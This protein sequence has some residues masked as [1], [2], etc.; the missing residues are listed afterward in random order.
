MLRRDH[1]PFR[2]VI[3]WHSDDTQQ[4]PENKPQWYVFSE[5][6]HKVGYKTIIWILES[7]LCKMKKT[8]TNK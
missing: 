4:I 7:I 1:M 8:T 2:N 5:K 6:H 3:A